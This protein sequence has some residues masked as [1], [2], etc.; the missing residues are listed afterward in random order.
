[1]Q[2]GGKRMLR[3][4]LRELI[5]LLDIMV[6]PMMSG[7]AGLRY[8]ARND[9]RKAFAR[10]ADGLSED[11]FEPL[12]GL[13]RAVRE[14]VSEPPSSLRIM[15]ST[16]DRSFPEALLAV[17]GVAFDY[18]AGDADYEPHDRFLTAEETTSWIRAWTGNQELDGADIRVV[19]EDGTGGYA[20]FWMARPGRPLC[21]QPV[22]FFGSEGEL[23]VVASDLG[24]F[25]WVLADGSGPFE[26]VDERERDRPSRPLRDWP[27][28]LRQVS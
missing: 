5:R 18:G 1:M 21:E 28:S 19:G 13:L 22:V 14:C 2:S 11:Y 4:H 27:G 17:A 25:L 6:P 7:T 24:G 3:R 10:R 16:D 12:I 20:A 26:A 9:M 15:D 23:G 8:V